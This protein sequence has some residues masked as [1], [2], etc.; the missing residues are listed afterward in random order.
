VKK[1]FLGILILMVI[2]VLTSCKDKEDECETF[3]KE[4][5]R[6]VLFEYGPDRKTKIE[7]DSFFIDGVNFSTSKTYDNIVWVV[8]DN[9]DYTYRKPS[10]SLS[11]PEGIFKVKAI[12]S[13][14][15]NS[16]ACGKITVSDTLEKTFSVSANYRLTHAGSGTY[17]I[18]CEDNPGHK[19][20]FNFFN[21]FGYAYTT[22]NFRVNAED[23]YPYR[24]LLMNN[25]PEGKNDSIY[26]SPAS[27]D[28]GST[29]FS[30]DIPFFKND[31]D[32]WG[33][34]KVDYY[35]LIFTLDLK[36]KTIEG[37]LWKDVWSITQ[38]KIRTF[39]PFKIKGRKL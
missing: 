29:Y 27:E 23:E 7:I 39:K 20:K 19:W 16:K 31:L 17:E 10:F 2:L 3:Q 22:R 34:K 21:S 37:E 30:G 8:N 6:I 13:R 24:F 15:F 35:R 33:N 5:G 11:F 38:P 12:G 25:Y 1:A 14:T 4:K 28:V 9:S 18:E 36:T 32:S 26:F